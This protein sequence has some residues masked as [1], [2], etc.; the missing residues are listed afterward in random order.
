MV[1][2]IRSNKLKC[3]AYDNC[4]WVYGNFPWKESNRS[5]SWD[6]WKEP[7]SSE[8]NDDEESDLDDGTSSSSS[9]EEDQGQLEVADLDVARGNS[10]STKHY[11]EAGS[12][13]GWL[14]D[15]ARAED[16]EMDSKHNTEDEFTEPGENETEQ[17]EAHEVGLRKSSRVKHLTKK[18][19][20]T[21]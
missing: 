1:Y 12:S 8:E 19:I 5:T 20:V 9:E 6:S 3:C 21:L 11:S 4:R 14:S 2:I 15:M 10:D 18:S 7:E 17:D 13:K 16:G